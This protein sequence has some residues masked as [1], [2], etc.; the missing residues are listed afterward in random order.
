MSANRWM[1][2][3]SV[4]VLVLVVFPVLV[5]FISGF[6]DISNPISL[7]DQDFLNFTAFLLFRGVGLLY[8][9]N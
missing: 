9:N 3:L 4:V 1:K 6:F 2:W 8:N 5:S 7:V